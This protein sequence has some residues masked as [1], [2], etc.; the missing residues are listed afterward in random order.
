MSGDTK[1]DAMTRLVEEL[2]S[3]R[4]A[5]RAAGSAG[6]REAK[7][8][9]VRAMRDAG[10]DPFEQAVPLSR[11]ANV[12]ATIPGQID[13]WVMVA[14]H[15]DH[16]GKMGSAIY[17]GADDNAAAVAIMVDVA[18]R[19]TRE[20]PLGRGVILAAFDAEEPPHFL[21]PVMGSEH[22]AR[23]PSTPLDKID[24]MVCLELLGHSLGGS[25]APSEVGESIFT[26]GTERVVGFGDEVESIARKTPGVI[27]RRADAEVIPPL[28]DY[29]AFWSRQRPFV[30]LTSGRSRIYHTP[31][32]TVDRL[33][34]PKMH[35]TS[36]A[37][38]AL[39]RYA[40][41]RDDAPFVLRE[42][43]DDVSSLDSL[44]SMLGALASRSGQAAL[45]LAMARELRGVCQADGSLPV[46][47]RGELAMLVAGLESALA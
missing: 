31:K 20:R 3:D 43:R 39:V 1:A 41:A 2:C 37:L 36:Q 23:N 7:R 45:G 15:Y 13:R 40:C 29:A 17:R 24:L 18:A 5:G 19:L 8:V 14:A 9:V 38:E 46:T 21:T 26:L 10:L 35:A 44:V 27:L 22:Y 34:W 47:R 4:C 30:L 42:T 6:G 28:S 25:V 11:G 12:L 33:D 16:L 32:D